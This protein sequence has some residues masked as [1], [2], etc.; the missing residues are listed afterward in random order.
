MSNWWEIVRSVRVSIIGGSG[1]TGGELLRLL[2]RHPGVEIVQ[3]TSESNAGSFVH[4]VHPNLRKHTDLKF[5]SL[6]E[7]EPVD[8]LFLGLPHGVSSEKIAFFMSKAK[9]IIDKGGDFRL[10]DPKAYETWYEYKHPHPEYLSQFVYGI[11]E[12][13]REEIK[14]ASYVAAAG[15][16]ATATIL[17]LYPFYKNN[18]IDP[19]RTVVE[20]KAGSS[21]GGAKVTQGSHHPERSG[22]VRCYKPTGHRHAAEIMQALHTDT[23]HFS[24]TSV[25]LV[26]GVSITAHVF[27]KDASLAVKDLWKVY[28]DAYGKE[29]FIRLVNE[30]EGIYRLPEPKILS[31]TN[32]CDIGFARD[33]KSDRVV[34]VSALDNLMKGAAGQALQCMNLMCGFEET[35]GLDAIGLHP[36]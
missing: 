15:C 18:L 21:Q 10:R 17:A 8:V 35:L 11:P 13:Y 24:A 3:V 7:L 2:L 28:R 32:M 5:S 31:G 16:N 22:V 33:E 29:P 6:A 27:L 23:L 9:K 19:K 12:L 1:Y 36:I 34:I 4:K 20:T 30:K 26:R 25:E 14:N